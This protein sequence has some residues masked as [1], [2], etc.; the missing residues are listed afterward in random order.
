MRW[1][2]V[3]RVVIVVA[4][5]HGRCAC[6]YPSCYF[7]TTASAAP[8]WLHG[9]GPKKLPPPPSPLL[10]PFDIWGGTVGKRV[11]GGHLFAKRE[12]EDVGAVSNVMTFFMAHSG[13]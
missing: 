3:Q 9:S 7:S 13:A 5:F 12:A 10:V 2:D 1:R 6:F 8:T 11:G 4:L